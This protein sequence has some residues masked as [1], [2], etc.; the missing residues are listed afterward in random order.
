LRGE[1]G[2]QAAGALLVEGSLE[3]KARYAV[4]HS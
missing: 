3:E 1:R 2:D 4:S